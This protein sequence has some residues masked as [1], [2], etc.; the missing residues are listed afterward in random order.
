MKFGI[1]DNVGV[2]LLCFKYLRVKHHS[3]YN[4]DNLSHRQTAKANLVEIM[5]TGTAC[6]LPGSI[7]CSN[8]TTIQNAKKPAS[9]RPAGQIQSSIFLFDW[10]EGELASEQELPVCRHNEPGRNRTGQAR[11]TEPGSGSS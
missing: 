6:V 3:L 4:A 5:L 8:R 1:I 11:I 10:L 7:K 2:Y 9:L